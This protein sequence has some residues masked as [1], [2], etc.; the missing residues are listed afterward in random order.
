M[1]PP[2]APSILPVTDARVNR[3]P[4]RSSVTCYL[5][6]GYCFDAAACANAAVSMRTPAPIVLE[7]LTFLR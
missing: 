2:R 5:L 7:T 4:L 1:L 3:R 6:P